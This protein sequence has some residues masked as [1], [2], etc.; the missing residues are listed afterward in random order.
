MTQ[1]KGGSIL[2]VDD[3]AL[4]LDSISTIL[5]GAGFSVQTAGSAAQAMEKLQVGAFDAVVS[6]IRMPG[7][8]GM[9]LLESI[10]RMA[11]P[12]PVM[13][14]TGYAD[15]ATTI[16]AVK[17]DAFDFILKPV[18][19]SVLI[20]TADKA[21]GFK[22]LKD[23]E[24]RYKQELEQ[25]VRRRTKELSEALAVI[26][27]ISNELV[28]RLSTAAEYRDSDTGEHILRI[29]LYANLMSTE[30]GLPQAFTDSITFASK[31]HDIGK[32]GISDGI[33]LK[34]G[35]LTPEE[36]DVIKNHA[37]HGA[38]ILT[39]SPYSIIRLAETIALCH[40]ERFD[41]SGYPNGLKGEAIPLEA[42][43]TIV[44]DQYDA[45]V[46]TRPYKRAF[47][48][49]ETFD[50]ITGGDGRTMP[51]HFD[52]LVLETFKKA[53]DGFDEIY[54]HNRKAD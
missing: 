52:P 17:K 14:M 45:L 26:S 39:G 51:S 10:K 2:V 33:L 35:P 5:S 34:P 22:R 31:L 12:P 28:E 44:C 25:T 43:I 30:M 36:F 8:T 40:H 49:P 38:K 42:R 53:A 24:R 47:T 50:I 19:P 23:I 9:E 18:K 32:I 15:I 4:A 13:L 20:D 11:A 41:G 27:K 7:A 48:H 16:D 54:R 29:G 1:N 46:M 37:R 3:D 21:V 6:E